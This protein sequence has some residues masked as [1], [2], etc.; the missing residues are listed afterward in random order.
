MLKRLMIY[1]KKYR[2]SWG[3]IVGALIVFG[4]FFYISILSPLAGDDWGYAINGM[5]NNPF[6]LAYEFYFTWSGRFFSE[7]YG[8]LVTPHKSLWNLLNPLLFTIIFLSIVRL[9]KSH[10]LSSVFLLIFLM[11]S[12]KDELRMETYTW[13]MGTTYVIPLALSLVYFT[14][15]QDYFDKNRNFKPLEVFLLMTGLFVIG[16]SME[17]ISA[18]LVFSQLLIILYDYIKNSRVNFSLLLFAFISGLSFILLRVSPGAAFRLERDHEQWLSL[19][20]SQQLTQQ[21]SSFIRLTFVEHRYLILMLGISLIILIIQKNKLN[22]KFKY[23]VLT[24]LFL[25]LINAMALT[26]YARFP[27]AILGMMID[28]SSWYNLLYWPIYAGVV[29]WM[30][31]LNLDDQTRYYAVFFVVIAGFANGI[32][33]LSPI[34]G[35]RSSLFTVYF[36]MLVVLM[37]F[38]EVYQKPLERFISI[39][40][41]LFVLLEVR[42]YLIKYR[43][44]S[45]IHHIRLN[46]IEYYQANPDSKEAW[47]VRYPAFSIHS[48]DIEPW[49]TYH[50]EVFKAYYDLNPNMNLIF[51]IYDKSGD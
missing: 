36:L 34:F 26:L 16:L 19:N 37:V 47:L 50:M 23:L 38:N 7:L 32:M 48:G 49:D 45:F 4:L 21:Y 11:L 13:L 30:V 9:S 24:V 46:E 8:F 18:I 1:T 41:I 2:A 27:N 40:L 43:E 20:I 22:A 3:L 14:R 31:Y 25:S 6:T 5:R 10:K 51:Y 28:A 42:S 33:M 15:I 39:I 44:L 12:I 17:N 29:L 35:Y